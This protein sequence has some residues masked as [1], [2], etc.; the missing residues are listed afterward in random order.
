MNFKE[1]V[2]SGK[3]VRSVLWNNDQ[4]IDTTIFS[5]KLEP[6]V[7]DIMKSSGVPLTWG[8]ILN[9]WELVE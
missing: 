9:P 2:C 4:H 6:F 5:E 8:E 1:A 7:L 3:K